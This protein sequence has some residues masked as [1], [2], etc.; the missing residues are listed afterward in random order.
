MEK[1]REQLDPVLLSRLDAAAR[2]TA[3]DYEKAT[4]ERTALWQTVSRFFQRY[5]LLLTPTVSARRLS[6]GPPA[7]P[8]SAHTNASCLDSYGR[9][10]GTGRD[11]NDDGP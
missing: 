1:G 3:I 11:M 4:H 10:E 8:K 5:D 6:P 9:R 7:G 2:L